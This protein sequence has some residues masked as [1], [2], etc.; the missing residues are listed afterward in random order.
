MGNDS[1]K[2]CRENEKTHFMFSNF[3]LKITPSIIP[4]N[5]VET[6]GP[7]ITS[8]YI[9]YALHA[10]LARLHALIRIHTPT[11]PGTHAHACTHRPISNIYL[12]STPT[13]IRERAS[14]L[15]YTYTASLLI[16]IFV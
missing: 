10:G 8:Q 2:S 15:S 5:V 6:E 11:Q 3:F 16:I 4:K 1:D 13:I 7:H 12:F 9:A 14:V